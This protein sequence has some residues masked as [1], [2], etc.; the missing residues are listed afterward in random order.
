MKEELNLLAKLIHQNL[1]P[2]T[3]QNLISSMSFLP[4]AWNSDYAIY[5]ESEI[6]EK[7]GSGSQSSLELIEK[8]HP[9]L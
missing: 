9:A 2:S 7:D 6:P 5:T 8:K 3:I 1:E 4:V